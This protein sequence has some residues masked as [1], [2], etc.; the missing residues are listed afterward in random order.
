MNATGLA[1]AAVP[2]C[3]SQAGESARFASALLNVKHV[4]ISLLVAGDSNAGKQ[5]RL[6]SENGAI[7]PPLGPLAPTARWQRINFVV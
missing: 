3:F 7:Y 5:L 2:V 1:L 4:R 6:V